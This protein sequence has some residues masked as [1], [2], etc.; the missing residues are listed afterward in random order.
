MTANGMQIPQVGDLITSKLSHEM[1]QNEQHNS[2]DP[3]QTPQLGVSDVGSSNYQVYFYVNRKTKS[4]KWKSYSYRPI[5]T[6][7]E[8]D[9]AAQICVNLAK[10]MQRAGYS[11]NGYY[12]YKPC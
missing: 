4:G 11:G 5:I 6:G 3:A 1:K 9:K 2:T 10:D 12:C 7:M 8:K